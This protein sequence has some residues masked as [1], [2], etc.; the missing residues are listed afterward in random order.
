MI[1]DNIED[2]LHDIIT[3]AYK[4]TYDKISMVCGDTRPCFPHVDEGLESLFPCN[5]FFLKKFVMNTR[6]TWIGRIMMPWMKS[7]PHMTWMGVMTI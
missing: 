3:E 4:E 1:E 2:P 5:F 6:R 7:P